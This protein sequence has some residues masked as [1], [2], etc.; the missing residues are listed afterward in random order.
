ME[1]LEITAGRWHL[2]AWQPW[3]ADRVAAMCQDAE[4]QRWT[5]VPVPYARGHADA[6]LA[7]TAAG[8]A[9][10]SAATWAV[11]DAT[12]PTPLGALALRRSALPGTWDVGFHTA[13]EARGRGLMTDALATACRWAF[14]ELGAE[15]VEWRAAVGNWASR[16][17]AE[18]AGFELEGIA[19]RGLEQRGRRVDC[20]VGA[21]CPG[22]P[23]VDTRAV[24]AYDGRSDGVVSLRA[25]TPADAG[26][27]ARACDDP[28]T[29]RWLPVP[30]PYSA[31]AGRFYVEELVVS[32]WADGIAANV[33]VTD[34]GSGE[35][36]GAVGLKLELREHGVGEVGYWT[37][38]WAR[39]RGV[40]GRA[41]RLHADWGH[42]ELGLG[43]VELL[44]DVRNT[45]SQRAAERA[46]FVREGIARQ[47]RPA[48]RE[49]G[50]ADLV[51]F[52]SVR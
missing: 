43:R 34:T 38:P 39:G 40:A 14:A 18:R 27:V 7:A 49:D 23:E 11:C 9:D 52:A 2:R 24:P 46:G 48:V 41:A 36:L 1:P 6:F 8:W 19:R 4:T 33:A 28:E 45:A 5:S 12:D 21:R 16:R 42:D 35:L 10:G 17:V 50:R 26:A 51:L 3:D 37:A 13:P 25:W 22:D 47:A 44:A 32:Q 29:R 31:E 30:V 15:R 20:W